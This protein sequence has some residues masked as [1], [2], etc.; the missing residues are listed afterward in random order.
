MSGAAIPS[1]PQPFRQPP[2]VTA[3]RE[4][5]RPQVLMSSG[6][7]PWSTTDRSFLPLGA[8]AAPSHC[9][10]SWSGDPDIWCGRGTPRRCRVEPC[11]LS[12]SPAPTSR[13]R[14]CFPHA[15]FRRCDERP[16][17]V[18]A[19]VYDRYGPPDVLSVAS[20]PVRSPGPNQ[21]LVK[22]IATSVNLS[23]WERLRGKPMYARI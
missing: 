12:H 11:R 17:I 4:R 3:Q 9:L 20:M 8:R 13:G 7:S 16:T 18:R 19:V 5:L 21:V 1:P 15:R 14:I 22:V 2:R 23:D 10:V 6:F